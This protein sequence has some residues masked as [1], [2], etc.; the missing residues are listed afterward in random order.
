MSLFHRI[1]LATA[2]LLLASCEALAPRAAAPA[3]G[4]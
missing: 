3:S 1:T 2:F 4:T